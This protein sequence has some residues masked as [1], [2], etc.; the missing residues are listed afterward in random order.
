[1]RSHSPSRRQLFRVPK[2]ILAAAAALSPLVVASASLA[3]AHRDVQ[4]Y[5]E[6][7]GLRT[8]VVDLDTP[9]NPV[10]PNVRAFAAT[11][12]EFANGTNDPG[13][14]ASAGT[15]AQGTLLGFDLVD[16]ARLW[17]GSDFDQIPAEQLAVSLGVNSRLTPVMAGG[18]VAGFNFTQASASGSFH[19][20]ANFFV[21]AP[22]STG[23]YLL[24]LRLR[25]SAGATPSEPIYIVFNQRSSAAQHDAAL[26]YVNN[27]L[28][29]PPACI[30]D[31]DGS[32]FV[33]FDDLTA[34][35]ARFGASGES[36][37]AL[38]GD[39]DLNGTVNFD[40]LTTVLAAFGT[41]CP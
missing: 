7:G 15:F 16:A 26:A 29:A 35:L 2:S 40:D 18:F 31:A 5:V 19:Q 36:G 12:G 10:I 21:T 20:H 4:M 30:G 28:L 8:G 33:N 38:D 17:D 32:G 11:F 6:A 34:V 37:G 14:N 9:G 27:V 39:A 13:F 24:K 41:V 22:A 23:V 25:V 3:Q 1:M